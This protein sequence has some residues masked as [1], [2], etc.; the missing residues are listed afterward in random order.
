MR[1]VAYESQLRTQRASL[2]RRIAVAREAADPAGSAGNA[3]V[4]ATH[5]EGAGRLAC[6]GRNR[7]K[8]VVEAGSPAGSAVLE[9]L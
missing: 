5:P 1:A 3:A 8:L 6:S 7:G 9:R 2:H 4:I